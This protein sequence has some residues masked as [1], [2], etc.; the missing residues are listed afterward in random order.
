[1]PKAATRAW[2]LLAVLVLGL[3]LRISNLADISD[4]PFF[5]RPVIDGQVYDSWAMSITESRA[6]AQPF[7]QDPL[8]P[9]FLALIYSV[10]GH[11][12]WAVYIVQL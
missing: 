5:T 9:Y 3:G 8:Y 1:M 7:Y 11:S 2:P 6:P 12:Y 4:S 10:F